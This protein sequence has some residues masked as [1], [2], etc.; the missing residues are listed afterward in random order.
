MPRPR[1]VRSRTTQATYSRQRGVGIGSFL[2]A[3]ITHPIIGR[4]AK[5]LSDPTARPGYPGERHAI[6]QL[7]DG[8]AGRANFMGPGT[9]IVERI[10]RGDPPRTYADKVS[11]AHDI[12]MSFAKGPADVAA[13]D[14]RMI[15]ALSRGQAQ[16][17]DSKFNLALGKYPIMAKAA[18]EK[19][20]VIPFGKLHS[21]G[22]HDP[23]DYPQMV[24]KLHELE[25]EG[26]GRRK[27]MPTD[28][29]KLKMVK[30]AL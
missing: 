25:Q 24:A 10:A 23:N 16:N 4:I 2:K 29:L 26:L 19:Y 27:A 5:T 18:A 9:A 3:A 13:A 14:K 30:Q 12:R 17:L 6:L 8:I 7:K 1:K 15:D 21:F 11:E 20:G 22:E 28:E